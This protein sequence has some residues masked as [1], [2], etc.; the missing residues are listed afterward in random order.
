M[1][2]LLRIKYLIC[3]VTFGLY[4]FIASAQH[5]DD[6][7]LRLDSLLSKHRDMHFFQSPTVGRADSVWHRNEKIYLYFDTD[8]I[9]RQ[10]VRNGGYKGALDE[11]EYLYFAVLTE[12]T[13]EQR[14][15]EVAKIEK[16]AK[17]YNS[18]AL[19]NEVELL[20][21]GALP[22][23]TDTLFDYKIAQYREL[24][25]IAE[26]RGDTL[27]QVRTAEAV[28]Q[29]LYYRQRSFESLEQ[30]AEVV[31]LL[32]RVS[33]KQ[34]PARRYSYYFIGE[35]YYKHGYYE[36]AISLLKKAMRP[37]HYFFDRSNMQ[38]L[39]TLGIYYRSQ[40]D[41][42][43]SDYYFRAMLESADEVKYRGEY[44]AI[45]ICNLGKNQLLR[46]NYSKAEMLMNK[47]L[48]VMKG[49]DPTFSAGVYMNLGQC[50]FATGRL[51]QAKAAI[52]SAQRAIAAWPG[53]AQYA[54]LYPLMSKYY[55]ATGNVA[56][57]TAYTDS[58]VKYYKLYQDEYNMS[59]IFHVEKKLYEAEK[60]AAREELR[61]EHLRNGMYRRVLWI[62]L[63][64][65]G[66]VL[67]LSASLF[68][69]YRKKREAHRALVERIQQWAN[70]AYGNTPLYL[71]PS[72][73]AEPEVVDVDYETIPAEQPAEENCREPN[74]A[75][76]Q[77]FEQL[78]QLID[79][80][81]LYNDS[82]ITIEKIALRMKANRTYLSH[83][84]NR[85]TGMNFAGYM[86]ELRIREAVR[87]ISA[88]DTGE[89][90]IDAVAFDSGF[91]DRKNFHKVFK[92]ITG[93]SPSE[94]RKNLKQQ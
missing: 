93:I 50:Y 53:T 26:M 19:I 28:L 16:V 18:K 64:F 7:P 61:A 90:T 24:Q 80:E 84:I 2:S 87:I 36:E 12:M 10:F 45:A 21:L 9:A 14:L 89:L 41:L 78:Q 76:R 38:A 58:T 22:D 55:A 69:N 88:D 57:A 42:D 75:D 81:R 39:N 3:L 85:C 77:L 4:S 6:S 82:D 66:I 5:I 92:K 25:Q 29:A 60:Q 83:A 27:I 56:A 8:S 68:Y 86:N 43:S 13:P 59:H 51:P 65:T 79:V 91:S 33:D 37:V 48:P 62:A 73:T 49:F 47:G 15:R 1:K 72:A 74:E 63:T 52:D 11:I 67:A 46:G 20:R 34:Y 35:I 40:N 54:E 44:D 71:P 31:K 94:F 32:D 70:V 17:Q 30:A 23:S